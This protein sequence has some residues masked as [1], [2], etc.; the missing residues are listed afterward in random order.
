MCGRSSL[1]LNEKQLEERFGSTFYSEDL[2]RYNPLPSFN[3]AP[4]HMH[5]VISMEAPEHFVYKQWGLIP[6]WAKA[7]S[8]GSKMINARVETI[9]EKSVFKSNLK[10][11]RCLVP[12]D[13]Y[14][15]WMKAGKKKIPYRITLADSSAF[16]VAGLYASWKAPNGEII[17]SFTVITQA[18]SA[19]IAH[20]H[21]RMPAILMKDKERLWLSDDIAETEVLQMLQPLPDELLRYYTVS[22]A[23]NK[24]SNN[25][26]TL[27]E[28]FEYD[29]GNEKQLTL[30]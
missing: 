28:P 5:P 21:D 13:G 7:A 27:I 20:I 29:K 30:F 1:T 19:S 26:P 16:A 17:G 11:H 2:E 22:E 15:E 9:L 10:K 3:I 23:V 12:F 18:A 6:F 4:T 24:V 25:D 8:I 14:Y